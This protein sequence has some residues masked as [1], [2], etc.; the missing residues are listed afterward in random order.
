VSLTQRSCLASTATAKEEGSNEH[1]QEHDKENLG[2]TRGG[3]AIPPKPS[4][5]ATMA[6]IKNVIAQLN[7]VILLTLLFRGVARF[8]AAI[9]PKV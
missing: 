5:A 9:A 6:M 1:H 3:A 7:M 8:G 4:T 2:D